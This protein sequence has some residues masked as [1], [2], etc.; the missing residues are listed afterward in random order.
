[1]DEVNELRSKAA[2]IVKSGKVSGLEGNARRTQLLL[3]N[4]PRAS[5]GDVSKVGIGSGSISPML[6]LKDAAEGK[7]IDLRPKKMQEEAAK[8]WARGT[9][10]GNYP[11]YDVKTSRGEFNVI[12]APGKGFCVYV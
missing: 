8:A 7:L 6:A 1:M 11:I 3:A 2:A 10:S 4:L 5:W 12:T 9:F